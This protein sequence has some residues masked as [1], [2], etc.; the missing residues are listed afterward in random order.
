[1]NVKTNP[2]V[3]DC[4]VAYNKYG[5]YCVPTSSRQRPAASVILSNDVYEPETINFMRANGGNGDIVH[6][7]TY[8]GDFLPALS[9]GCTNGQTIWAFE[10]SLE[11]YRCAKLTLDINAIE[12]VELVH[13]GLG[14]KRGKLKIITTDS[15]GV[16]LGGGCQIV[17][18]EE[19]DSQKFER[20]DIVTLDETI[21]VDREI[22]IVQLDVEGFEKEALMGALKTIRRCKPIL[23]LE[24]LPHSG[25]LRSEWFSQNILSLGYHQDMKL[26]RNIVFSCY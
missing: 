7:G 14:S 18:D 26:H 23:I 16:S 21:G 4:T 13:A 10:P 20:T 8:F 25:L 19:T 1:M 6:A 12:N 11:N 22:S 9:T 5:G 2:N 3:L 15:E 24:V 17:L